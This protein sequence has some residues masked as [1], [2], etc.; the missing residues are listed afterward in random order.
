MTSRVSGPLPAQSR[1]RRTTLL[2]LG[3]VLVLLA[4]LQPAGALSKNFIWKATGRQGGTI[5]LAGSVHLLTKDYY[6]LDPAFET[7]LRNA[8][9][10]VEE[11]ELG[12][13]LNP[14]SQMLMVT[15]GLL[16]PAQSLEKVISP[17]TFSAVSSKV[18]ELG[19]PLEGLKRL[20]PWSVALTL[21]AFE[22][23]RAGFDANLGLDKHL[24]DLA[25][26]DGKATEGLETFE[27]QI[28]RLDELSMDLQ[29]RLLAETLQE[30]ETSKAGF[31]RVANAWKAGDVAT[32]EQ[33]VLQDLKTQ[34]QL[35]ARLLVERNRNWLPKIEALFGRA[36]PALVV[37][38]AAHLVGSDG[39]LQMLKAKGYTLEQL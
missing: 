14:K 16:P 38:G 36:R 31:T 4:C 1:R 18:A 10:L 6:P 34:P 29:D 23:Q 22:W 28:G 35:Y 5:Y 8:D 2:V 37:V 21:Q 19:L 27:Y 15:R 13:M 9:L 11:L 39:L 3:L 17:K 26:A 7:A 33:F 12:E 24:Y 30:L 20:K 32:V 25:K